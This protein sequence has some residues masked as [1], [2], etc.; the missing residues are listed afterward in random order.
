MISSAIYA[1]AVIPFRTTKSVKSLVEPTINKVVRG[2][3]ATYTFAAENAVLYFKEKND[4]I[5]NHYAIKGFGTNTEIGQPE[6][7]VYYEMVEVSSCNANLS[8]NSSAYN[9][10]TNVNVYPAQPSPIDSE[11]SIQIPFR[12]DSVT[13]STNAYYP[14]SPVAIQEVQE[15]KGRLFAVV[16]ICPI[17]YNPA[18]KKVRCNYAIKYS[19]SNIKNSSVYS[20]SI[21]SIGQADY[22][23]V[24]NDSALTIL[25]EFINWKHKQG[26]KVRVIPKTTWN[27]CIEVRDS[28][29]NIYNLCNPQ[30]DKFLLII[31]NHSMVPTNISYNSVSDHVYSC[32]GNNN[33]IISDIALGRIPCNNLSELQVILSKTINYQQQPQYT[34]KALHIS[35]FIDA[36]IINSPGTEVS[37]FIR[38]SEEIKGYLDY[39]G[40]NT[41][42]VYYAD[43]IDDPIDYNSY[44]GFL[45]SMPDEILR[46]VF[47]WSGNA[48]KIEQ[49]INNNVNIVLYSAHGWI[50]SWSSLSFNIANIANLHND[51]YPIIISKTCHTGKFASIL[52]TGQIS[53]TTCFAYEML[54]KING[55]TSAII[56]STETS[57]SGYCD[58]YIAGWYDTIF[59]DST[60]NITVGEYG[61]TDFPHFENNYTVGNALNGAC[62]KLINHSN[63][64]IAKTT[65]S[66][67]H[68]FGD[69]STELYTDS[70]EELSV[71]T[72]KQVND[73]II[74]DTHGIQDCT[75]LLIP[76]EIN[77]SDLFM[78]ADSVSGRY[79]FHNI[80]VPYNISVQKHN[81]SLCY[82][83][84]YDVYL[85]NHEYSNL[86]REYEGKDVYIGRDV[87]NEA[88][89][90]EVVVRPAIDLVIDGKNAVNVRNNFKV[91]SGGTLNIK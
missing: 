80:T 47:S 59:P 18:Q 51:L 3:T 79:V 41:Q 46:P 84:K 76:K 16:R 61:N 89:E 28:I 64:G 39:H 13:Y 23:I 83:E 50:N 49:A 82:Y 85:Q 15:Y 26:Y 22:F 91:E 57:F 37:R 29:R 44:Y 4:V 42:R 33:D 2:Q 87:T 20:K 90:G 38:T 11:D 40:Y 69:P 34:G 70:A 27:N 73:S 60:F 48:N 6:L 36:G 9:V 74:I 88:G 8:I 54:R 67:Y 56:A 55:G 10:L 52:N 43:S 31:G 63:S 21:Q 12:I 17:Q 35:K 32:M 65:V 72:V 14:Q 81:S 1:Q 66:R 86:N 53:D 25:D 71:V 77:Q 75:V 78:R 24:C 30:T 5:Y 19:I 62:F 7:P 45:Q 58:I 68:C